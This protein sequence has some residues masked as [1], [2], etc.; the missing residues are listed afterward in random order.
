MLE[1]LLPV[2]SSRIFMVSGLTFKSSIYFEFILVC[3]VRR[4]SSFILLHV[5]VQFSQ[6]HLL[7]RSGVPKPRATDHYRSVAY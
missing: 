5:Y 3:G 1:I 2:F 7:N 4:W 6:Y